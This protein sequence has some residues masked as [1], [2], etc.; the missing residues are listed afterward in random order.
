VNGIDVAIIGAGPY[1]LSLAAHLRARGVEYRQFGIPMRLWR[2]SMPKGM[3]L[4]SQGF[5]SNLSDPRGSH[6]LEAFCKAES[7][8]Y[9][10]CG[11]PV[12]LE[13]FVS[14]GHW[15]Q[16]ELGLAV[17]ETLVT[18]VTRQGSGFELSLSDG[19]RVVA[20]KVVVAIGVE[21]F[22][23]VPDS[24]SGLS[25]ELCTHSSAHSDP[26]AFRDREVVIVGGGQSALELA[27]LMHENGASVRVVIRRQAAAWNGEPNCPPQPLFDRLRAPESGLGVGWPVW[28][29]ANHPEMFRKLPLNTRIY[30]ARTALGPSGAPW[31]RNRVDGQLPVLAGHKVTWAKALDGRVC[32]GVDQPDGT[33]AELTADHVIAATGYRIDLN[34]MKF[35]PESI[36][37]SLRTAGASPAVGRDFQSSI[38]GLYFIGPVVAPTFGPIT[39]FVFGSRHPAVTVSRRL[40]GRRS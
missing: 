3:Y 16:S 32:L 9:A 12:S 38:N 31:L 22:A 2:A 36:R 4:K 20:R 37:S 39:R 10:D 13:N 18:D 15:F 17:E 8:P 14:Y 6:T 26:A 29:Y 1:G 33:S 30:R 21:H 7:R 5:A 27:G 34:R 40:A 35:L 11:L 28:F 23:Y 25:K 24:M 19:E